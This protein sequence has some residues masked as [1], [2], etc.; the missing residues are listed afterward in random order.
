MP[1]A[2]RLTET[3]LAQALAGL[4]DSERTELLALLEEQERVAAEKPIDDRPPLWE[5][6]INY[7]HL[8]EPKANQ[9]VPARPYPGKRLS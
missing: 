7:A 8:L 1:P 5:V 3:Q 2:L 6:F 9:A 4:S